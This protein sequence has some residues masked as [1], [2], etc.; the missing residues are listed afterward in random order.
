[1]DITQE[2]SS[3][4]VRTGF[5]ILPQESIELS[6]RNILDFIG[7]ALAGTKTEVGKIIREFVAGNTGSNI[8]GIFGGHIK[9]SP[10]MAAFANGTIA[11]ALDYDDVNWTMEAHPS[12]SIIPGIFAVGEEQK[13]SGEKIIEAYIIGYEIEAKI[14]LCVNPEHYDLGWHTTGT[15]GTFGALAGVSKILGLNEEQIKMAFGIASSLTSGIK[16]N[17]GTMTKPLHAGNAA[18]NGIIAASLAKKGFTA[19]NHI[20][21]D[22]MGIFELFSSKKNIDLNRIITT[23]GNPFEI[24]NSGTVIKPY[25]CCA[26][27]HAAIDALLDLVERHN[28][29]EETIRKVECG[30]NYRIPN[31]MIYHKPTTALEGKFSLEYCLAIA[32]IDKE[33]GLEQFTDEKVND[34]RIQ[35]MLNKITVYVHPELRTKESLGKKFAEV[36]L[37]TNNGEVFKKRVYKPLGNPQNPL[38]DAKLQQKFI[39]CTKSIL[40]K[41][42]IN[43]VI[44]LVFNLEKIKNID[45]IINIMVFKTL[46]F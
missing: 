18:K 37:Y 26:G 32:I 8:S 36:T 27:G 29:S 45:E 15:L 34:Y 9:T 41:D 1:M 40:H 6:K 39:D 4:I 14:G 30:V 5:P 43:Q 17:F 33:V 22:S 3:F 2:L 28:L 42:D 16:R 24:V 46:G 38:S 12:V 25:P 23:L 31:T 35:E 11:H 19:N 13:T 20:L 21:D 44:K 10:F 7:V